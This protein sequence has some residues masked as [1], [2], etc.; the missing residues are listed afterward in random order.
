MLLGAHVSTAGGVANAPGRGAEIDATAIQLFTKQ[1]NRWAEKA[2]RRG[3][4]G[5]VPR[6]GGRAADRLRVAHDSYLINLATP[7]RT[8]RE[9]SYASF[10]AS[11]S[12]PPTSAWTRWSPTRG[13]PPTATRAR[14]GA[15]RGR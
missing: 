10:V 12:A 3:G 13:T 8:L 6:R 11:W 2:V 14:A 9:R 15:E 7:D 4:R 5:G 1:P